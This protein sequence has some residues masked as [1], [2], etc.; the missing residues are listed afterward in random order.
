[1]SVIVEIAKKLG[2]PVP[3]RPS[4]G[5]LIEQIIKTDL[6]MGELNNNQ[7]LALL[8]EHKHHPVFNHYRKQHPTAPIDFK[9]FDAE[10]VH[11]KTADIKGLDLS[12][13]INIKPRALQLTNLTAVKLDEATLN[14]WV[15]P[16]KS[17]FLDHLSGITRLHARNAFNAYRAQNPDARLALSADV[18]GIDL[19]NYNF[20]G[21][22][23]QRVTGLEQAHGLQYAKLK[24]AKL[25]DEQLLTLAVKNQPVLMAFIKQNP[26]FSDRITKIN[27]QV[28]AAAQGVQMADANIR[29]DDNKT[30]TFTIPSLTT[31]FAPSACR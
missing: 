24:G 16:Q 8:K 1:M 2:Y 11:W 22:D 31:S 14:A 30:A 17:G 25:S 12:G 7:L 23:L 3:A 10:S 4:E 9:G 19:L 21:V 29:C 18:T 20:S 5:A 6:T 15:N 13:A 28:A 27:V 26:D